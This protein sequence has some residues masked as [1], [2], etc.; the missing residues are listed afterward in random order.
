MLINSAIICGLVIL[1]MPGLILAGVFQPRDLS[2]PPRMTSG[3]TVFTPLMILFFSFFLAILGAKALGTTL[4]L[5]PDQYMDVIN[6]VL[7]LIFLIA[8]LTLTSQLRPRGL[9]QV[10]LTVK[11]FFLAVPQWFVAVIAVFPLVYLASFLVEIAI[12][13]LHH[14]PP[15]PHPML[16]QLETDRHSIWFGIVIFEAAMLVPLAEELLFRGL[17]QT[18]LVYLFCRQRA[19]S[20]LARWLGV[21]ITA[22][23]FAAAHGVPA[24]FL[25]LFVLALGLGYLYERTGNLWAC[26]FLH[27]SFNALQIVFFLCTTQK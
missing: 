27:G 12:Q 23:I 10:G 6:G 17:L 4:K 13:L 20:A 26:A 16:P 2:G 14:K 5:T 25:P 22:A 1:A 3:E 9:R 8:A 19:P 24:F 11:N 21:I 18:S 15:D 7:Y